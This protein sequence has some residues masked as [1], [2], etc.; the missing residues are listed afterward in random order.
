[1]ENDFE[2]NDDN[3]YKI[4]NFS[5]KN[6]IY[7]KKDKVYKKTMCKNVAN[8]NTCSQG[9]NCHFAHSLDEQ[10]IDNDRK[11]V[12][13]LLNDTTDLSDI[14]LNENKSLYDI[15]KILTNICSKCLEN[16]CTG[17]YNCRNGSC[18]K[19]YQLCA[20]D[21]NYGFCNDQNCDLIHL[22]K[23]NLK[24]FYNKK[25]EEL[26]INKN[27]NSNINNDIIGIVINSNYFKNNTESSSES[28]IDS[29]SD[30]DDILEDK[31]ANI[32]EYSISIFV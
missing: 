25:N 20:R 26:K 32:D 18:I 2:D 30:I 12:Y 23:R 13:N 15:L 9:E 1:M 6:L 4:P 31:I 16:H 21:L 27:G 8:Y 10:V 11:Y 22:S 14:N 24:P 19:K 5:N 29:D 7:Q 17:G 3:Y 28:D